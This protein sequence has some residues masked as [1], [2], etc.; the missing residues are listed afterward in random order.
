MAKRK[1]ENFVQACKCGI[2]YPRGVAGD[3]EVV[4]EC[5]EKLIVLKAPPRVE[6]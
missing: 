3:Y 4:C 2:E 1:R 5:G 6:E